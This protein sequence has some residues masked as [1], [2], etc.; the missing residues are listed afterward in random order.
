MYEKLREIRKESKIP[1]EVII[2][3]LGLSTLSAYYK[4]ETGLV[5]ITLE[6]A[7]IIANIFKKPIEEIFFENEL[8]CKE[9]KTTA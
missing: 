2:K 1:V 3:E 5:P 6:E 7:K 4:K 8:S 9:N